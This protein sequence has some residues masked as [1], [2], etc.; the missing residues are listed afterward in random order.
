MKRLDQIILI[1]TFLGFSWLAMQ[2]VHELGHVLGA[3]ATGG[4]VSRVVL[5]P[6][7]FSRTDVA[8]NP[9]PLAVAWAGPAVG[10]ALP[11]GAFLLA[12]GFRIRGGYLLRFFAGFCLVANGAYLAAGSSQGLADAGDMLR[13]GSRAWHLMLFGVATIPLG[14][15]LWNGLGP[16]FGL[17]PAQGRV[18]HAAALASLALLGLLVGAELLFAGR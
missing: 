1:V 4:Q 16:H 10:T 7:E 11:L 6:C 9:H 14:L 8:V 5:H 15:Y 3:V 13:H 12:S 17:G 2:A 18:N